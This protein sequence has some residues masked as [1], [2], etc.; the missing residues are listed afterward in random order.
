MKILFLTNLYPP[1]VRGG[2]EFLGARVVAELTRQGHKVAVVTA[3]PWRGVKRLSPEVRDE[4]GVTVYRFYPLNLYHYMF[5]GKYPL[6]VRF[7][8]HLVNMWNAHSSRVVKRIVAS[9]QPELAVS[10]NLMGLGFNLPHLLKRLKVPHVHV[11]H[12]VQL[13]HP[14]GLFMWGKVPGSLP[15]SAYQFLTRRLFNR[16]TVAAS[17]SAW[18][19]RE[20]ES[21]GFFEQSQRVVLPNP[22][23]PSLAE[24]AVK[25]SHAPFTLLYV[26]Q[27][28]EHKGVY[29]L[30]ETLKSTRRHDFVLHLVTVGQKPD[31]ARLKQIIGTDDRFVLH[32]LVNQE[33]VDR[34]LSQS[35]L[36]VM[37]SLCYENSPTVIAQSLAAGT[38]VLG[39]RLGGIPELIEEGKTGWLFEPGGSKDFMQKLNWCLSHPDEMLKAGLAGSKAMQDRTL[40][41][42]AARLASFVPSR[43]NEL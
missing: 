31:L 2:A 29:W 19:L 42:Y 32:D 27:F 21:H 35:H 26:G 11:L 39:S 8:W 15:M 12:D 3:V 23:P 13:L 40:E 4:G 14:S 25:G 5:A 38:P 30:A 18:L 37:P 16:V 28:Q 17:P 10:Y 6:P 7:L 1:Y 41:A 9:E 34:Y 22:V 20:H 43:V 36:T 33:E 24:P